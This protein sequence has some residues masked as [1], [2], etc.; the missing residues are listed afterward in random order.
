MPIQWTCSCGKVLQAKEEF[1]GRRSRCPGCGEVQVVPQ[2]EEDEAPAPP[3]PP[4]RASAAQ[5]ASGSSRRRV[6]VEDDDDAPPPP[7]PPSPSPF[8]NLDEDEEPSEP[9]K[10]K[11][12]KPL[13]TASRGG[14]VFGPESYG[15]SKGVIGGL[16][17][18]LIAIVWFVGGLACDI[19]FF[20]PPILFIIGLVAFVKGLFEGNLAG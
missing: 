8:A 19:I 17:M 7:P 20:Y 12:K 1:A 18:M 2:N 14:G 10:K 16:I 15:M 13:A 9:K 6:V 11:K 5:S 3:P 4:P